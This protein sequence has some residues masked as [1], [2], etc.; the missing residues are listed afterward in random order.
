MTAMAFAV[1]AAIG[2]TMGLL[3]GGGSILVVPA[4]TYLMGFDTKLAIVT[5]LAVVGLSAA[6][7]A[8]A[9]FARGTLPV[10]PAVIIGLTTMVG[11]YGGARI[12]AD[13]AERTQLAILAA[14]M[15][16]AA[17]VMVYQS[18]RDREVELPSATARP[19]TLGVIGIGLGVITGLV[20]V[21]GGFLIVPALVIAGGLPMRSASS[22]SLLAIALGASAGLAG[23]AGRVPLR[24]AFVLPFAAVASVA[25]VAG[26]RI[27]HRVAQRHLQRVFALAI[28]VIAVFILTRG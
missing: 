26:G 19:I 28:V 23:Y 16:G 8:L 10:R 18:R 13:L 27:A 20:G 17:A 24:W 3:G 15:I 1:A 6:A 2:F 4:L 25:T 11:A 22:A 9:S 14:V 7:G 21:G 12:G 5:S